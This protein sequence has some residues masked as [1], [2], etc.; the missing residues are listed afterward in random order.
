MTARIVHVLASLDQSSEARQLAL[1]TSGLRGHGYDVRICALA[2]GDGRPLQSDLFGATV[3][4]IGRTLGAGPATFSR[5]CQYLRGMRP[6]LVH[7]WQWPANFLGRAAARSTGIRPIVSWQT[8]EDGENRPGHLALDR[9]LGRWSDRIVVPSCAERD[10]CLRRGLP[11]D[12]L[13]VIPCAAAPRHTPGAPHGVSIR[14]ELGVPSH[15][16][17]IGAAGR[18]IPSNGFK[19]L[20]W[21]ADL[22]KVVY[23]DVHLVIVG[24]GSQRWR[25]ERFRRQ[26]QIED[27]VHFL[28]SRRDLA[29][30]MPQLDCFW[31][32]A[33]HAGPSS[34]ILEAMAAAVPVVAADIP[35][36]HELILPEKTGFLFPVGNRAA[37]ARLTKRILDNPALAHQLGGSGQE[38]IREYFSVPTMVQRYVALYQGLLNGS[39]PTG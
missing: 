12:K 19:D 28:G 35:T 17:V 27:R 18:F 25:L 16:R 10:E 3:T 38:R 2:A 5:L 11:A 15:A 13:A 14:A 6:D 24:D 34:V 21:T 26:V 32:G 37:L 29:D 8:Q 7:T 30:L 33:S 23:D 31:S 39:R 1:L 4:A 9:L 36:N 22:L 20:I